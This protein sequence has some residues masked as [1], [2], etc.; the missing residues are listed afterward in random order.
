MTNKY[1][2]LPPTHVPDCKKGKS[3]KYYSNV[4]LSSKKNNIDTKRGYQS[5]TCIEFDISNIPKKT[6][7]TI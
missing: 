2:I 5:T 6:R 7:K 3:C 1:F 4:L